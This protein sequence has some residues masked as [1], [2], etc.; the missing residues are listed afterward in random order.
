MKNHRPMHVYLLQI[1]EK[2]ESYSQDTRL[3]TRAKLRYILGK[4]M[5]IKREMQ[6]A[7]IEEMI[8][9]GL[10]KRVSHETVELLR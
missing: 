10:I 3:M 8:D 4:K 9:N 2:V 1:L 5:K 7:I 6:V